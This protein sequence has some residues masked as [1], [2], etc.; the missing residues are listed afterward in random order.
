MPPRSIIAISG[1]PNNSMLS[2]GRPYGDDE[3]NLRIDE[4]NGL[5]LA[6]PRTASGESRLIIRLFTLDGE[7]IASAETGSGF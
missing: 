7:S 2:S 6:L 4:I 3:W 5:R 1:L